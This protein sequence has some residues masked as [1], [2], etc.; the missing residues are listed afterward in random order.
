MIA[1]K[2]RLVAL[3]C[4]D[5]KLFL[6][7]FWCPI[8]ICSTNFTVIRK[9]C[10]RIIPLKLCYA[11][12]KS[13]IVFRIFSVKRSIVIKVIILNIRVDI[14]VCAANHFDWIMNYLCNDNNAHSQCQCCTHNCFEFC[15]SFI[16]C[17]SNIGLKDIYAFETV[18][19][20]IR[21][22]IFFYHLF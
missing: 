15:L 16:K 19:H 2:F 14:W 17:K 1:R 5:R 12:C 8:P 21:H 11:E 20:L 6:M 22:F 13:E 3:S 7:V 18:E 9:V 4:W 10:F